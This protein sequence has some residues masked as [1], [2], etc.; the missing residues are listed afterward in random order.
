MALAVVRA[1]RVD[2]SGD[3]VEFAGQDPTV[4]GNEDSIRLGSGFAGIRITVL[5]GELAQDYRRPWL[6]GPSVLRG[7][8]WH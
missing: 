8:T 5:E 3:V 6:N 7:T 2:T 1:A 4:P